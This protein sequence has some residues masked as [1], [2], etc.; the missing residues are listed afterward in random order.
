VIP[1]WCCLEWCTVVRLL[2]FWRCLH[3]HGRCQLSWERGGLC[4]RNGRFRVITVVLLKLQV[5]CGVTPCVMWV[6]AE[7]YFWL[8]DHWRSF[9]M[10]SDTCLPTQ[11]HNLEDFN[12]V[13]VGGHLLVYI[14]KNK[15]L[16][17]P[18]ILCHRYPMWLPT[19]LWRNFRKGH[20]TEPL[21]E[22]LQYV[23]GLTLSTGL[24]G[25]QPP[26]LKMSIAA[27]RDKWYQ[28]AFPGH[29]HILKAR[30]LTGS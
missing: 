2:T 24:A 5:F 9:Q 18:R 26:Y 13:T 28:H 29:W 6:V 30:K 27:Q 19:S 4:R 11:G 7:V 8:L 12:V 10:P 16:E 17:W 22:Y 23:C 1:Q 20:S 25:P 3:L 15:R 14:S 21:N